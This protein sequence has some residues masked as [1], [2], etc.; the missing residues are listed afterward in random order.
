M[1]VAR[2]WLLTSG[3]SGKG[4]EKLVER[5]RLVVG[6]EDVVELVVERSVAEH[7]GDVLG[8]AHEVARRLT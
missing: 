2:R 3:E 8:H 5:C 7:D 4:G 1:P 6:R